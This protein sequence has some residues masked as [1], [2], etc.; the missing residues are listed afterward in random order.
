MKTERRFVCCCQNLSK[1]YSPFCKTALLATA[2]LCY[3]SHQHTLL[4]PSA[5]VIDRLGQAAIS[6]LLLI[7]LPEI[8]HIDSPI[9]Y[10][11]LLSIHF[12]FMSKGALDFF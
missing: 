7:D 12:S 1:V 9:I 3:L 10:Y 4:C 8:L 5:A 2:I 11:K 6:S